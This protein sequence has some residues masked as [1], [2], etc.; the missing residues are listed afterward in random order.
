M[1]DNS[2]AHFGL[3]AR[4]KNLALA[5]LLY[6]LCTQLVGQAN[7]P[8]DSLPRLPS[9][10]LETRSLDAH[11]VR[12]YWFPT[13]ASKSLATVEFALTPTTTFA[14]HR[15]GFG[16]PHPERHEH[17]RHAGETPASLRQIYGL[18][19]N[20]GSGSSPSLTPTTIHSA[21][22]FNTYSQTSAFRRKPLR[23]S[24]WPATACF[25]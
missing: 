12:R 19:S 22:D 3:L 5:V 21:G 9:G 10:H 17:H 2:S 4:V 11:H 15:P 23:T 14:C 7:A 6:G 20:G 16:E 1:V 8:I 13:A 18:P 25:R 24:T